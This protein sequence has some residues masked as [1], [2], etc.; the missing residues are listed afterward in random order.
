MNSQSPMNG[1][2][3]VPVVFDTPVNLPPL[4]SPL[5]LVH[6]AL[7]PDALRRLYELEPQPRLRFVYQGTTQD[8]AKLAGPLL[9]DANQPNA[10]P[11]FIQGVHEGWGIALIGSPGLTLGDVDTHFKSLMWAMTPRGRSL[12]NFA[13]TSALGGLGGTLDP[14]QMNRLLG[15]LAGLAGT[16]DGEPW[17]FRRN[18]PGRA[19]AEADP[20][21]LTPE[22]LQHMARQRRHR[23]AR[24]LSRHY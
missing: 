16:I 7:R 14:T 10:E 5:F 11:H 8:E 2:D 21:T 22:N 12:F 9:I 3:Q 4:E 17:L 18:Q 1:E 23:L 20:L 13:L 19:M 24:A 15:P 6:Q